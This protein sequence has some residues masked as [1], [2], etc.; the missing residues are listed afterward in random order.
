MK[1][2]RLLALL[3]LA[4]VA[5]CVERATDPDLT[6]LRLQVAP[7][8]RQGTETPVLSVDELRVRVSDLEEGTLADA[9]VD[10][11]PGAV[12]VEAEVR[13]DA[14]PGETVVI[15][16]ALRDAGQEIY[17]GGP[18]AVVPTS[19]P[20]AID[21][22]YIGEQ[23]CDA[24]VGSAN[25][26]PIGG[27]FGRVT[28]RLELGD[29]YDS[30]TDSFADRWTL[31]VPRDAGLD[32][33]AAS[34]EGSSSHLAVSLEALDG[35][36]LV[37]P[38]TDLFG[39]F[40]ASGTYVAVV[41]SPTPLDEVSYELLVGEFDRCDAETGVLAPGVSASQALTPIDCPLASGRAADLW[42]IDV[43]VDTPY[44]ID[45]ESNDFDAQ[46]VLT[47]PNVL[48]PFVG[49]PIDQDDDR[50]LGSNA[51]LAGVLPAG[52]YRVWATSFS[53]GEEGPYQISMTA[54]TPGA[55]TLEVRSVTALGVGGGGVCGSSQAFLFDFGFEDGDGDL[56]SPGG[57]T[58]RLTGSPS[59][60]QETKGLDW[61]SFSDLNS[62]AGYTDIV[63]CE[64]F[65]SDTAKLAEFYIT[66]AYGAMSAIYSTTLTP[67]TGG[68]SGGVANG[69]PS[70]SSGRF[71]QPLGA[72]VAVARPIA[73]APGG[74][75]RD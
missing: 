63:T 72:G 40:I 30:G 53:S 31:V 5:S 65:G 74:G 38:T 7:V 15:E 18:V 48:D 34:T 67:T 57:V 11:P 14:S 26:G 20:V 44:R 17:V 52:S 23:E 29:C 33:A 55:P 69:V 39:L 42:G 62:F 13:I 60:T 2:P 71:S 51:L 68:S 1:M 46:L 64:T 8:F 70:L 19:E 58:I 47:G 16:L 45:L 36:V 66:D 41:T 35:T 75:R 6:P 54:L 61:D 50:G 24:A 10:I 73:T 12:E 3:P 28:G 4:L 25:I 27:A 49:Q 22:A 9:L 37:E 59:G 56:Y 32:L 43:S 21:V